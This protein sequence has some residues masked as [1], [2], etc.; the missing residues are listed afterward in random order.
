MARN[1]GTHQGS[2]VLNEKEK[3][4][5]EPPKKND[6]APERRFVELET[7]QA[8]SAFEITAPCWCAVLPGH[9]RPDDHRCEESPDPSDSDRAA[10][11]EL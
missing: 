4:T 1:F 8:D 7:V 6:P 3:P 11:Q 5:V 10:T 2:P 9:E